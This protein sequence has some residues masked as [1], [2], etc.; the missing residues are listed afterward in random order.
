MISKERQSEP[1]LISLGEVKL[2]HNL[3]SRVPECED[4]IINLEESIKSFDK[5]RKDLQMQIN[6]QKS[7][8]TNFQ[9]QLNSQNDIKEEQKRFKEK[10]HN[11]TLQIRKLDS[12]Q[13]EVNQD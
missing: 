6:D 11:L 10:I 13:S 2:L 7:I 1:S 9:T 12:Q 5:I 8:F 4:R 3:E